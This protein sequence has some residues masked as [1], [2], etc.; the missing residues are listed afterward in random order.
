MGDSGWCVSRRLGSTHA[1]ASRARLAEL[2]QRWSSEHGAGTLNAIRSPLSR[3]VGDGTA[4]DSPL[5]IGLR[6]PPGT[7]R[8]DLP[9]R[10]TLPH[11]PM[12]T[13]RGG[14]PDGS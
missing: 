10:E 13:H 5:L 2:E 4:S 8:A 7:W 12:V 1:E 3:L 11:F 6:H 14:F 9:R